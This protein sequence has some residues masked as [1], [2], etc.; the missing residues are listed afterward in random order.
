MLKGWNRLDL[1]ASGALRVAAP[2]S[3]SVVLVA[4]SLSFAAPKRLNPALP[5]AGTA[6]GGVAGLARD[7]N[8]FDLGVS[9]AAVLLGSSGFFRLPNKFV[10]EAGVLSCA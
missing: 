3:F 9:A 2:E 6:D 8:G 1:D 10:V 5:A 7:A 4:E